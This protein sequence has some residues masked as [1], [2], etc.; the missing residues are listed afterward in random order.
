VKIRI[1][2][3]TAEGVTL[4]EDIAPS[5]LDLE[6][7]ITRFQGP[8]HVR[9]TASRITNAVSIDVSLSATVYFTCVRCLDEFKG[10]LEKQLRLNYPVEKGEKEIDLGPDIREEIILDYP[11]R[12]LCRPE[13]K[14]ICTVCGKN[15]N[16]GGCSCATTKKKTL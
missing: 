6:T 5:A 7:E 2:R 14:G 11:M 8:V 12:P 13:C 1:A 16:E 4:E 9:A 15:L 3:I 10:A